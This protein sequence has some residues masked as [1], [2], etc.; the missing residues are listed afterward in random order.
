MS[1]STQ[2]NY[3]L[4][5]S[6]HSKSG[7]SA[8]TIV[9]VLVVGFVAC[10]FVCGGIMVA[11]MIPAVSSARD[12]ARRMHCSNNLKQIGLAFH[13]YHAAYGSL[14]PAFT[15]D[16]DGNRLHSWRTLILPFMEQSNLY[17]QIDFTKPWDDPANAILQQMEVPV[18]R[19][20]SS[21]VAV[22][23][24]TYQIIDDP[25][26]PFPGSTPSTFY[27]IRDGLSNTLFVIETDEQD[28]VHW[29]EPKDQSQLSY[30]S[31]VKAS[32]SGGRNAVMGDGAVLFLSDNMD[33]KVANAI[34]TRNGGENVNYDALR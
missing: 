16:A 31:A 30:L 21:K 12:A 11:L 8:I 2:P 27:D 7:A 25:S 22:G 28:A 10:L 26:S 6:Q 29:A 18:F 24:T 34:A 23:M 13:N 4:P 3:E 5:S 20:P 19:C 32:H 1:N 9:V 14:P 17:Q 33:Q 15:V